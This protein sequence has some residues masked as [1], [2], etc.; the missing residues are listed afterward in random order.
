ML[1]G[2]VGAGE[3]GEVVANHLGLDFNRVENLAAV[4]CDN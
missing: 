3:L 1:D 4:D 2:L